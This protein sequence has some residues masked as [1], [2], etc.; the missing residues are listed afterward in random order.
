MLHIYLIN[1]R[2]MFFYPGQLNIS[3]HVQEQPIQ[4]TLSSQSTVCFLTLFPFLNC[5]FFCGSSSRAATKLLSSLSLVG[6]F[7][8]FLRQLPGPLIQQQRL[9][10]EGK[11]QRLK[12]KNYKII[13]YKKEKKKKK[14]ISIGTYKN[15]H[16]SI[17]ILIHPPCH[18]LPG[19]LRLV[20]S[21]HVGKLF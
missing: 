6:L 17:W 21:N 12:I 3:D 4:F 14:W 11:G 2:Y 1:E 9:K 16:S 15:R 18:K 10:I 8:H 13:Y 5:P 7:F 20:A 19:F